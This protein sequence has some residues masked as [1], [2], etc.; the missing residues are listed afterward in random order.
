MADEFGLVRRL[1]KEHSGLN[2][3]EDKQDLL[4]GKLR[5]LLREFGCTTLSSGARRR[6][7]RVPP[8]QPARR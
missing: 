1:L 7:G 8:T 6:R 2:L 4:E 3:G 5:P